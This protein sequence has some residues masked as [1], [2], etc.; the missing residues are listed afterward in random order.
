MSPRK[1][2]LLADLVRGKGAQQ[3]MDQLQFANKAAAQPVAKLV[4]SAVANAVNNFGLEL[5]NLV[6][7]EISVDGGPTLKRWMP[8]AHGR[9]TPIMKRTSHINITLSEIK[10]SGV[11]AGK[12]QKLDKPVQLTGAPGENDGINLADKNDLQD[13]ANTANNELSPVEHDPRNDGR[14]GHKKM[15]G[16]KR[17]FTKK[18]FA[19][20]SG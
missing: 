1:V 5:N 9:A 2:R 13:S 19:R 20:K 8:R 17:G 6:V 14:V 7:K 18:T 12:Q 10:D 4:K 3:A 16:G 11:K 15:E